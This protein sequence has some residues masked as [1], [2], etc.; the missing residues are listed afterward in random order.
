MNWLKLLK[1]KYNTIFGL[2]DRERSLMFQALWLLPLVAML[3]HLKG[4]RFTQEM[5]LRLPAQTQLMP[6]SLK[7]QIWTTVRMVRV[8]VRYNRPWANCLKQSLVLWTLLRSQGITTE[9]RIG[10]QRE[11]EKFA[12]HAW[13]EYQGMILNDTNDVRQRFQAF[14]RSVEQPVGGEM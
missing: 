10:V 1:R 11:S 7:T 13:V 4:L 6:D 9:L 5:L 14:D 8:A 3:L 2:P 12:A